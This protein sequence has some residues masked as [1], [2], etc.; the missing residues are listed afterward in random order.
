[1][2]KIVSLKSA[3]A[4]PAR[5]R[6]S[7]KGILREAG[8]ALDHPLLVAHGANRKRQVIHCHPHVVQF[9][10][11]GD[12]RPFAVLNGQPEIIA[13]MATVLANVTRSVGLDVA[14]KRF[15]VQGREV[16]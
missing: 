4:K 14:V 6:P 5:V 16:A 7:V 13:G 3:A 11:E 9:W 2:R 10:N 1:M 12:E 8:L 15:D